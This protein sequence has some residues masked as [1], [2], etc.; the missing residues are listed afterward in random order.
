MAAEPGPGNSEQRNETRSNVF[1]AAT[2][3]WGPDSCAVRIRNLSPRGAL[4][5]GIDLPAAGSA[6]R[7]QRGSLATDGKISW[8]EGH[9]GGVRFSTAIDVEA[10]VRRVGH[11]GQQRVDQ[12]VDSLRRI[13]VPSADAGEAQSLREISETLDQICER[14]ANAPMSVEFAEDLLRL[15]AAAQSLRRHLVASPGENR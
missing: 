10:W 2:L 9:R 3:Y 14:L 8:L 4:I 5:D 11:P 13:G 6:V 12:A 1:L 7:V 15:D